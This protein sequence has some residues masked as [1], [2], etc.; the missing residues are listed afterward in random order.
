MWFSWRG[1]KQDMNDEVHLP[2]VFI[3]SEHIFKDQYY[4]H[5]RNFSMACLS[6]WATDYPTI[7]ITTQE[8]VFKRQKKHQSLV[9]CLRARSFGPIPE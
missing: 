8:N 7:D 5:S 1:L 4:K 3:Y 6:G 9:S 2:N